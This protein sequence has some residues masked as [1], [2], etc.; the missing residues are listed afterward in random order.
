MISYC[1]LARVGGSCKSIS[2]F[3]A[4]SE[5]VTLLYFAG[6]RSTIAVCIISFS[7]IF[8]CI[9]SFSYIFICINTNI[10]LFSNIREE[11]ETSMSF[12]SISSNSSLRIR[13]QQAISKSISAGRVAAAGSRWSLVTRLNSSPFFY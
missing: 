7:H 13:D 3:T 1:E 2:D 5:R 4:G 6:I 12:C 10:G 11:S 9:I 8:I